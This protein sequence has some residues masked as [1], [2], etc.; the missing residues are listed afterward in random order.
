MQVDIHNFR[1]WKR[2]TIEFNDK[3]IILING[4]SGSGKSSILNS[5]Y[6]AITGIGNKIISYGEK[7]C[8]VTLTFDDNIIK[9]IK[10]T[11][12]PNR[13]TVKLNNSENSILEDDE[14]QKIIDSVYGNYFQQTS[15]MTQKMIH[16]FLSLTPIEKMNFLHKFILDFSDNENNIIEIKKKCKE[17]LT[18]FKKSCIEHNSKIC[19]YENELKIIENKLIDYIDKDNKDNKDNKDKKDENKLEENSYKINNYFINLPKVNYDPL[20]FKSLRN[21]LTNIKPLCDKYNNNLIKKLEYSKQIKQV[22]DEIEENEIKKDNIKNKI[23]KSEYKGDDYYN[24]LKQDKLFYNTNKLLNEQVKQLE[25]NINNLIIN[26]NSQILFL[27]NEKNKIQNKIKD[28]NNKLCNIHSEVNY[29]INNIDKWKKSSQTIIEYYNFIKDCKS[30][31][32]F[33]TEEKIE[34][35]INQ[36]KTNLDKL[37]ETLLSKQEELNKLKQDWSLKNQIHKCP[38]CNVFLR[39]I[40]NNNKKE[41]GSLQTL[42]I[43]N[44]NTELSLEYYNNY[45]NKLQIEINELNDKININ[46]KNIYEQELLKT[47]LVNYYNKLENLNKRINRA[48]PILLNYL[49]FTIN[50]SNIG[51]NIQN[52]SSFIQNKMNNLIKITEEYSNYN[53]EILEYELKINELNDLIIV[54]PNINEFNKYSLFNNDIK[55]LINKLKLVIANTKSITNT[56]IIKQIK[57]II[58]ILKELYDNLLNKKNILNLEVPLLNENEIDEYMLIQ[59]KL[60]QEYL[61]SKENLEQILLKINKIN[62]KNIELITELNLIDEFININNNIN[63]KYKNIESE[64]NE[65][66]K[67]EEEYN[68]YE[69]INQYYKQWKRLN[70]EKNIQKYMYDSISNDIMIHETFLNKINETESISLTKC[71]DSINYYINDYLEKFFSNDS[72]IV[73]IVPFKEK[74]CIKTSIDKNEIKPGIDIKV[75]YKGEEVE[76]NSLSGGEY[77]RVSLAIMLAFNNISK[78]N[79]ILLDE[80]ISSLDSDL[81]NDILEKLKEN[82]TDKRIIVV[83]HQLSTGVFDQIINTK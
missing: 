72:M 83:A 35:N 62:K 75:C 49:E 81:T 19:L 9:E 43:N 30:E 20:Y 76:L 71:I 2:H 5:I 24:K 29:I 34:L 38:K 50:K 28:N 68:K 8:N 33:L 17:K 3:G 80:S 70:N 56:D 13:L 51:N 77:D 73:D 16:S 41:T 66:Y 39:F 69:K 48:D 74:K 21:E 45:S 67:L 15:Y 57:Y 53:N 79:I 25:N 61:N 46:Q 12:N 47:E 23:N 40:I 82:M 36:I 55:S 58:L 18:E 4:T 26:I 52:N 42:E 31:F 14:A 54:I 6:F 7:K 32:V 22:E 78:S 11:K 59:T 37:K 44:N 63:D 10:R 64:I 27:E 1:C 60:Q 65:Y